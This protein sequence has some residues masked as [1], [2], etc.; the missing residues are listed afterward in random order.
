[1]KPQPTLLSLFA[2]ALILFSS[3]IAAQSLHP[4]VQSILN[5][6]VEPEGVVFDIETLD[7]NALPKL[8]DYVKQ[9]IRQLKQR[10]PGLDIA[11]VSHGAEEFALQKQAR[12]Q[13]EN[14]HHVFSSL[15]QTD[16]VS[17]HVCGAVAGLKQLTQED[18]PEF[19]SY[20]ESGM[21]QINDYRALGYTIIG[22]KQL[23]D[24]QRKSLFD[25]PERYLK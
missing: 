6:G 22:I 2:A 10:F 14:L 13:N 24:K 11:V 5:N 19:V 4:Q 8:A 7:A 16:E 21:A 1:M 3:G 12:Q 9:Q 17:I 15:V 23:D 25:A 20:S 18:F